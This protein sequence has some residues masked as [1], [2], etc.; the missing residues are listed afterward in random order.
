MDTV[1]MLFEALF[2]S[3]SMLL[4]PVGLWDL[5]DSLV[6]Y[7]TGVVAFLSHRNRRCD[8][9]SALALESQPCSC[10]GSMHPSVYII[11]F[12]VCVIFLLVIVIFRNSAHS[13]KPTVHLDSAPESAPEADVGRIL[14]SLCAKSFSSEY[15]LKQHTL[16]R[17]AGKTGS[18]GIPVSHVPPPGTGVT[19]TVSP[20]ISVGNHGNSQGRR[21]SRRA[22]HTNPRRNSEPKARKG[23][24]RNDNNRTTGTF[25]RRPQNQSYHSR[26]PDFDSDDDYDSTSEED[27]SPPSAPVAAPVERSRRRTPRPRQPRS[28][29]RRV[30]FDGAAAPPVVIPTQVTPPLP[31]PPL[32]PPV[33]DIGAGTHPSA[34]GWPL[35]QPREL[36]AHAFVAGDE[37]S[38]TET[39]QTSA[40]D[41]ASSETETRALL[42]R[43]ARSSGVAIRA[44][45]GVS[46]G[47]RRAR[48]G[49]R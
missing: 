23:G 29:S 9:S 4:L 19:V 22:A 39:T 1:K 14:C 25:N 42:N 46:R 44:P 33:E 47:R 16:A 28:Q 37:E 35:A 41:H 15:A 7:C 31:D 3:V 11:G 21:R 6:Y 20:I 40:T 38:G 17:H 8:T 10:I 12:L 45:R 48:G 49:A 24:R 30:S 26:Y 2:I 18:T 13:K 32:P 34:S 27:S 5:F 36:P 43:A